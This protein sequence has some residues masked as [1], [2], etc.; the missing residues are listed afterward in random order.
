MSINNKNKK[1]GDIAKGVL[2]KDLLE[3]KLIFSLF[4]IT[5]ITSSLLFIFLLSKISITGYAGYLS[6]QAGSISEVVIHDTFDTIYWHGIYGLA[7]RVPGFTELLSNDFST[8]YIGRMDVFFDCVQSDA[9][10]GNEVYISNSS[11]ISFETL[12]P[13]SPADLD[14]I[15]GCSGKV[16]CAVNT[17]IGNMSIMVGSRNITG[18]PSTYTYRYDGEN[19]I[20]DMGVLYDGT[21]F[22]YA[23]HIETVQKSFNPEKLVNYQMLIPGIPNDTQTYYF[24]TDPYDE[25][26]T[27]GGIG[28]NILGNVS[29][30]VFDE[31]N[32]P[33]FNAT[34]NLAGYTDVTNE[35]GYYAFNF[36]VISGNYTLLGLKLGYQTHISTI[37]VN[38]SSST[39][40][41]NIILSPEADAYN[42]TITS[43]VSGYVT[44]DL[45]NVLE[46]VTIQLGNSTTT[47]NS[48]GYY[49]FRPS[50][51]L[52]QHPIIATKLFYDNYYAILNFSSNTTNV[53]HNIVMIYSTLNYDFVTG[54]YTENNDDDG[55]Y[56][57][58]P[59]PEVISRAEDFWVS[60]KEIRKEV[61]QN[62]FIEETIG[63]YNFKTTN[64]D[65][66]FTLSPEIKNFIELDKSALSVNPDSFTNLVLTIYGT[67]PLGVYNGTLTIA[68]DL[69]LVI[70]IIIT[71]VE[72][73]FPVEV[74]L[75]E[76]DLFNNI[77]QPGE[78]LK[79][80]LSLQNLLRDQS[81]KVSLKSVIKDSEGVVY[82]IEEYDSEIQN[83]LTL[84]KE[85]NIPA[86]VS[87]GEYVLEIEA[88]Y[89]NLLS[90]STASF[91]VS[92][93]IYLYSF[94]GIPLW[95]MI[96]IISFLSFVSLNFLLYRKYEERKK[97]YRVEVD[98]ATL[99]HPGE[100]VVKLG[101]VAESKHPAYYELERLTTH[102]IVAGATGMGK[103]I[104]AQVIIEEALMNDIAVIVFDP[105]AQWSGMLRKC[106]DKK[107]MSFYSKFGLKESDARGFKGNVRQ[108]VNARQIIDINKHINP[109]QIQI[110]SLNKL[111]PKDIDFF[112]ANVIRQ[113]FKS[114][115]KE[116]PTLK[117]LVVFDE[118]HRLLSKFGGSGEGFL[119]IERACREF[120]KWGIGVMLI[121]QVLNDFVG[122]IKANIN[123]EVQTRTLEE[124]DLERIKTK[125]GE[126]FLKSLVRAEVGVAMFQNAEYNR[127]RPYFINFRPILHS[128][129]RLPDEELEKYNRYNDLVDDLAD[130][131]LQLE[132]EGID[133]FDLKMELKLIKDKIMSGSF[134][135]V[136]IYLEGLKPRIEKE[137]EKLGKK[138]KPRLL[139]LANEEDVKKAVE[140]AKKE[141][142]KVMVKD[143]GNPERRNEKEMNKIS[144][145]KKIDFVKKKPENNFKKEELKTKEIPH[146]VDNKLIKK[147]KDAL[148]K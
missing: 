141:R 143:S 126:G 73:K 95:V 132:K 50:L 12:E 133:I 99:P 5:V 106:D 103:S 4:L 51:T 139:E 128:T 78:N 61:R 114:D 15:I 135:V 131:M 1:V 72:K 70:P 27:G 144:E 35:N 58:K 129:R 147:A 88:R 11:V 49:S 65:L 87:E 134:S 54:P 34:V 108:V 57:K 85:I 130:Q 83:S 14:S 60:T 125:Y 19:E 29:G 116:S 53:T 21:N 121:S 2:K 119:Q 30:Y 138:P 77:V 107:M 105:T 7:L 113:V 117:V 142:E 111:D 47:T 146:I 145:E 23:T 38:F 67:K 110:F 104:S 91:I 8:G 109:G 74:L 33:L 98:Y 45:G 69:D 100:K 96:M 55:K 76:I 122:E 118:V 84:L 32:N 90:R 68:G 64:M 24:F 16:D 56:N 79:Y 148:N 10:G 137:W 40:L 18:I 22:V 52:G 80:K 127:G 136:E 37:E 44:S 39:F 42:I 17:F 86:N 25:C 28:E 93:P 62:T 115:P 123:T 124:S 71:I 112:I 101:L 41:R 36:T 94:F 120:R 92:R 46:N 26:P 140:D 48:L 75:S 31:N 66:I 59:N 97:R 13:A 20:F 43:L 63:L 82:N 3:N 81:Y 102:A 6:S 9:E 89:L